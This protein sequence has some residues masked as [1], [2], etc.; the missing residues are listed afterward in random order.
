MPW[1]KMPLQEQWSNA[2]DEN[3]SGFVLKAYIAGTTTPTPIAIDKNGTTTVATI[4][5]NADGLPEVSGNE[6]VPYIDRE[7]KMAIFENATDAANDTNPYYGFIDNIPI[8]ADTS[9]LEGRL[10]VDNYTTLR[11]K[12]SA[13]YNDGDIIHIT[14][15]G[16]AGSFVVKTG[17]VTDNGGTLIVFT[18]DTNRYAERLFDGTAQVKWFDLNADGINDDSA[19]LDPALLELSNLGVKVVDFGGASYLS[20]A[21]LTI[22]SNT[23]YINGTIVMS[24][25]N[26]RGF[27]AD[28]LDNTTIR[29]ITFDGQKPTVGWE[30]TNN[31]DYGIRLGETASSRSITNVNI[32]DCTFKD[33][34][35]DGIYLQNYENVTIKGCSFINCR[36]WGIVPLAGT[37][38]AKYCFIEDVYCDADFG[39][40]PVGKEFP[41]GAIDVEPNNG[42]LDT[43]QIKGVR[44]KRN[45]VYALGT[46]SGVLDA[47]I[48]DVTV[49]NE[50][51]YLSNLSQAA[52][53][54]CRVKG[55]E[56]YLLVD[57]LTDSVPTPVDTMDL[58]FLDTGRDQA[59]L[60]DT[61][62]NLM[63]YDHGFEDY[64]NGTTSASGSGTS[65]GL[66]LRE[67]DGEAVYLR[68]HQIGPTSGSYSVIRQTLSNTLNIE[69]Q[70]VL[71]LE[72]ER[73]D[74]NTAT[75]NFLSVNIGANFMRS[76]QVPT[77][78]S[79]LMFA[80][81]ATATEV[82]PFVSI[83][84][85]G[86]AGVQVNLLFRKVKLFF[87]PTKIIDDTYR[88]VVR[89]FR[90]TIT[91]ATS[92]SAANARQ[93]SLSGPA[94]NIDTIT[95]GYHGQV[96]SL[97]GATAATA[98]TVRDVS[99][100][101]SGNVELI[102][103][104]T[105]A[106]QNGTSTNALTLVY[107]S[108]TATWIQ[109]S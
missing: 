108:G 87:N 69:D 51:L 2:M 24:G 76:L 40:G 16:I 4:T 12:T 106:L 60:S 46:G 39:G 33:I 91:A 97:Y 92:I 36:R 17:T 59:V 95:D 73:T 20:A 31:F 93:I 105:Y 35:L 44:G 52:I 99:V 71:I 5:F 7:F 101:A 27:K 68:D 81:E 84:L 1:V 26:K 37:Y 38:G 8:E 77:G 62:Q 41:L 50:F 11:A 65:A 13:E 58:R 10:F 42:V 34:G 72:V 61:R 67:I 90:R 78:I 83:G 45:A 19:V 100:S 28:I 15:D 25:N 86:T 63:P 109:S 18:D 22:H 107:D 29:G 64:F 30:T 48:E 98:Y 66:V 82:N 96:L 75:G 88:T 14:D 70:A 104:G 103:N 47:S 49:D 89:P 57:T 21:S 74:S 102:N 23:E 43:I 94:S 6:V 55:S 79:T 80:W 56:G 9:A 54:N 85:N 3:A 32:V 53:R